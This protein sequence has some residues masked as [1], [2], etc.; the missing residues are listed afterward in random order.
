[1]LCD[2]ANVR[3]LF[4]ISLHKYMNIVMILVTYCLQSV[5]IDM[6]AHCC[7]SIFS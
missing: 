2:N 3:V 7:K 6:L 4:A 1:M 5:A